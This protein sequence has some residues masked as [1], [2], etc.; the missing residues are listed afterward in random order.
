MRYL[1][2]TSALLWVLDDSKHLGASTRETL[3]AADAIFVS[4]MS[5]WEARMKAI[6]SKVKLP[7]GFLAAVGRSGFSQLPIDW[8]HADA[9]GKLDAPH[10]DLFD[11]MILVQAWQ[12]HL[13][14]VTADEALLKSH[15]AMCL[16][17]RL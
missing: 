2:D 16:D 17:A 10:L 14:L 12:E 11:S 6:E 9:A 3:E 7:D 13:T 8:E 5:V 1:L 15:P 4:P